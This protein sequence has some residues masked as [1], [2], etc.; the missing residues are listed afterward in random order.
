M[1]RYTRRG[2][3]EKEAAREA[4]RKK[5]QRAADARKIPSALKKLE[6][7]MK[8]PEQEGKLKEAYTRLD[9]LNKTAGSEVS[10][11]LDTRS[12]DA[13]QA[14]KKHLKLGGLRGGAFDEEEYEIRQKLRKVKL[15]I[16]KLTSE[17][18]SLTHEE[19]EEVERL[20]KKEDELRRELRAYRKKHGIKR[21]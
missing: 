12:F 3:G 20:G 9:A 5:T 16:Y 14:A 18:E 4:A 1:T 17:G 6:A 19:R 13:L 15:D 21:R 11:E 2:G 8:T 10:E 7:A